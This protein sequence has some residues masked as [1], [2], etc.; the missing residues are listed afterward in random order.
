[1]Q[2]YS[3]VS[4]DDDNLGEV[5]GT[6]GQSLIVERGTLFKSRHALPQSFTQIDDEAR[7]VRTTLSKEL[8]QGSPRVSGDA[9]DL[10]EQE[11]A[12]YYGLAEGVAE[13]GT[14]GYGALN[15]DDPSRTADQEGAQSG[16]EPAEAERARIR[17][18]LSGGGTY[19]G[20]GRPIIPPGAHGTGGP[21]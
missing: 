7:V 13:P 21:D 17:E 10:D 3:V 14:E 15:E 6:V 5:V 1:M 4:A 2:G 20:P 19:G 18:G 12:R 9:V 8:I 11:V 16:I